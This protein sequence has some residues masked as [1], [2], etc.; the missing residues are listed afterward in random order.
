MCLEHH[1]LYDSKT[2][3]H[4]NYTMHEV[5]SARTKLYD[6]VA[7]GKHLTPTTAQPYLSADVDKN[8][9][10]GFIGNGTQKWNNQISQNQ[11]FCRFF[12]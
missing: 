9:L 3:Q 1:S 10:G 7:E 8:I 12:F 2:K 6:L 11:K 5:K 4:K